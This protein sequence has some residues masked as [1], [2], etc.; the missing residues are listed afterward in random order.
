MFFI[1]P[2]GTFSGVKAFSL[3]WRKGSRNTFSPPHAPNRVLFRC[4]SR[5]CSADP[6]AAA[7]DN[8]LHGHYCFRCDLTLFSSSCSAAYFSIIIKCI[9][10][11]F[12]I[13]L[14]TVTYFVA[15]SLNEMHFLLPQGFAIQSFSSA[16]TQLLQETWPSAEIVSL[17]DFVPFSVLC[18]FSFFL[19]FFLRILRGHNV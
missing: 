18:L 5:Y 11:F 2:F 10:L 14:L 13:Y 19:S 6:A 16:D 12:L 1:V 4:C 9:G 17:P 7:V 15:Y 8:D 3:F